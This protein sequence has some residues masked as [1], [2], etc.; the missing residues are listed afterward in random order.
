MIN[1][2]MGR[3]A[4]TANVIYFSSFVDQVKQTSVFRQFRFVHKYIYTHTHTHTQYMYIYKM[5]FHRF[6]QKTEAMGFFLNPFTVCSYYKRKFV[7]CPF[8]DK[9][10][11]GSYPFANGLNG[12]NGLAHLLINV[13]VARIGLF[14]I[15]STIFFCPQTSLQ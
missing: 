7:T 15:S 11:N 12:L 1:A 10:T 9:G 14:F 5:P 2:Q 3:L 13:N 4:E 8:A 6:K